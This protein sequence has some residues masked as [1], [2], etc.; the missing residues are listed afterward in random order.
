MFPNLVRLRLM[1]IRILV[2]K[3]M[4]L[5][6]DLPLETESVSEI[7]NFGLKSRVIR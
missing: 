2:E 1:K 6:S 3:P 5:C 4:S 7:L